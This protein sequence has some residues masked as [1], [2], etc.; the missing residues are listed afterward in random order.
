MKTNHPDLPAFFPESW[1]ESFGQDEYGLWQG[2]Y[3]DDIEVR[4][5]WIPPGEFLMGSSEEETERDDSEGPQH[6]ARFAQGFWLAETACTQDLWQRVM[7]ENPSD[8][9]EDP[10]NPVESINWEMAKAFIAK[11]NRQAP[12]LAVRLPSEA[13]WEYA[14]RAGTSTTF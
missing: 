12:M 13:E 5:R 7:D 10:Q 3:I 2:I 6:R 14:C 4:F 8:F 9:K 1:A 11:L